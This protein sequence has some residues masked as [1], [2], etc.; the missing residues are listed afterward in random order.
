MILVS[1][2]R[3]RI[4]GGR[5]C[6]IQNTFSIVDDRII[7]QMDVSMI[8][9]YSWWYG[10]SDS[11]I[12]GRWSSGY[13]HCFMSGGDESCCYCCKTITNNYHDNDDNNIPP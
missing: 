11:G 1:V 4:R 2:L 5:C 8:V 6:C 13:H 3:S 7:E 9:H 10:S 12:Y